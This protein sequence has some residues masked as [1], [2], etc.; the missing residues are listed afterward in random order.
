MVPPDLDSSET[1]VPQ[2]IAKILLLMYSVSPTP[3]GRE[4]SVILFSVLHFKF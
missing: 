3:G 2:S 4:L 1:E